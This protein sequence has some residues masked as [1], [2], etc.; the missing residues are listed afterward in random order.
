MLEDNLMNFFRAIGYFSNKISVII[1]ILLLYKHAPF[2]ISYI[3]FILFLHGPINHH[4]KDYFNEKR[5]T[6]PIK[7]L[8]S[9]R[10]SITNMGMPS[11]HT[12][13]ACFSLIYAYLVTKQIYPWVLLILIV[14]V[15]GVAERF[16]YNNHNIKQLVGGCIIGGVLA[17]IVFY[18][19]KWFF[20]KLK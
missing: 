19:T 18:S 12:Q 2:L 3:M 4:L 13:I 8:D 10:F 15:F 7:F 16:I 6:N 11:G 20:S 17:P 5:P 1:T 9:D 14:C